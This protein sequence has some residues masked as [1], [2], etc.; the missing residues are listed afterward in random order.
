MRAQIAKQI[1]AFENPEGLPRIDAARR[2]AAMG[3]PAIPPLLTAV[4]RHPSGRTRSM[5]AYTLGY[6]N[7]RRTLDPLA[8]VLGDRDP[9]VRYEVAAALVRIGDDRGLAPL[10]AG[11]EDA[12]PRVRLR[13]ISILNDAVGS[14]YGFRADDE[15]LDRQA[16]VARW[17]G[18]LERRRERGA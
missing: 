11:L 5:A 12:D 6:M 2:L 10:V 1:A 4:A 15:P 7:D 9:E 18:W 3:E 14:T 8:A 13:C 17:R 16:A